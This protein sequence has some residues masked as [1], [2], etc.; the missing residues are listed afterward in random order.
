MLSTLE[1]MTISLAGHI[2]FVPYCDIE[3]NIAALLF[4][5][6]DILGALTAKQAG[7]AQANPE[8]H[9]SWVLQAFFVLAL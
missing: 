5:S 1:S 4:C 7:L 2:K 6:I 3:S 8:Q 9:P